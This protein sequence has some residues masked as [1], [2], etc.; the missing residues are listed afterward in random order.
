MPK[1]YYRIS[2]AINKHMGQ[3]VTGET[4]S[5]ETGAS[6]SYSHAILKLLFLHNIISRSTLPA[7]G[8]GRIGKQTFFVSKRHSID[9]D[10]EPWIQERNQS[11]AILNAKMA[12]ERASSGFQKRAYKRKNVQP[13]GTVILPN[14][15][16]NQLADGL[17]LISQGFAMVAKE[18]RRK[19]K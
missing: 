3:W 13:V 19:Y 16:G 15:E 6:K 14:Q 18:F 7:K 10:I 9:K 5:K 8:K 1:K 2:E 17:E 4:I 12:K 11:F